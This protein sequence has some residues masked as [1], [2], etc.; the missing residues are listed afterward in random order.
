[1]LADGVFGHAQPLP[2]SPKTIIEVFMQEKGL[3][4]KS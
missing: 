2:Y 1:M 3:E 4:A